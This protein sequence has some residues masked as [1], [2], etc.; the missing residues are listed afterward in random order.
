MKNQ[1][2]RTETIIVDVDVAR[3]FLLKNAKNRPINQLRIKRYAD[4][5]ENGNWKMNGEPII[6]GSDGRLL[7]GQ[8][9]LYAIM[10]RGLQIPLLFCFNVNPS[11]FDTID[12]G[13]A[14]NCADVLVMEEGLKLHTARALSVCVKMDIM[15]RHTGSVVNNSKLQSKMTPPAVSSAIKKDKRY[16]E[17]VQFIEQFGKQ[18]IPMPVSAMSF[19]KYRFSII[20]EDFTDEWLPALL[21]GIGITR[22]ND[23]RQWIRRLLWR[24]KSRTQKRELKYKIGF[25]IR[26]WYLAMNNRTLKQENSLFRAPLD[27]YKYIVFEDDFHEGKK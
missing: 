19:L 9:R 17:S 8:H 10:Y 3:K 5:M 7:D 1:N 13:D 22:E 20:N 26:A 6:V 21:T 27:A 16:L 12:I 2:I 11:T 25:I 15:M 18:D 14:R 4:Q 24:E 23:K